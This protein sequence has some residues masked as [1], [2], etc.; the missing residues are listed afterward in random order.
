MT[1]KTR[2][3]RLQRRSQQHQQER[4]AGEDLR[5]TLRRRMERVEAQ[6]RQEAIEAGRLAEYEQERQREYAFQ[7]RVHRH[8]D[9]I[10][11]FRSGDIGAMLR[12]PRCLAEALRR[13]KAA[14]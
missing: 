10:A 12:V 7:K 2:L 9:V 13:E 11:A 5:A 8:P 14:V 1:I 4:Q 6:Y 3:D